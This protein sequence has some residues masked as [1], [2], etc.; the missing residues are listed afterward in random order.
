MKVVEQQQS[1][2]KKLEADRAET[3]RAF[4]EP[5]FTG[6]FKATSPD[7][8]LKLFLFNAAQYQNDLKLGIELTIL[9]Y[10]V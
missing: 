1:D 2:I 8:T 10:P 5:I 6:Q 3:V 7:L 4:L 9:N